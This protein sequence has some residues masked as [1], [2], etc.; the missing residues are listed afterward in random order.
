MRRT[1]AGDSNFVA[2]EIT[3][4]DGPTVSD[5]GG[6]ATGTQPTLVVC[7]NLTT[8]ESVVIRDGATTW[9]CAGLVANP[10]DDISMSVLGTAE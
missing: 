5:I 2:F 9:D 1:G 3:D 7:R 4:P 8:G 6:T 10:G